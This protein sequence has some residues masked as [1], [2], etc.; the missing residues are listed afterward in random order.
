MDATTKAIAHVLRQ[1]HEN[2]PKPAQVIDLAA[3]RQKRERERFL[4]TYT[5][6]MPPGG[7]AA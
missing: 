3:V 4:R 7:R 6:P 5:K 2:E 1:W